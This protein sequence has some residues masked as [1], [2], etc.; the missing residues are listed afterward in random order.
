M[1][2]TGSTPGSALATLAIFATVDVITFRSTAV[3]ALTTV[4]ACKGP[5][6]PTSRPAAAAAP[7]R[8]EVAVGDRAPRF[9]APDLDGRPTSLEAG[10]LYVIGFLATW[11]MPDKQS[12]P[13][14]E[15]IFRRHEAEGVIVL[16]VSIDDDEGKAQVRPFFRE[17]GG[18]FPVVHDAGHRISGMFGVPCSPT[19]Y[20]VDRAGVVRF[21]HCGYHDGEADEIEREVVG[22]LSRR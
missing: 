10:K 22:L 9:T 21:R 7:P 2:V 8:K 19:Y 20:V 1:A 17:S 15:R 3:V 11:S 5:D 14:L 18:T 16:G 6:A 4:L 13:K 12:I